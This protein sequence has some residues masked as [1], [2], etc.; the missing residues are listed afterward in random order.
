MM[1]EHVLPGYEI[2]IRFQLLGTMGSLSAVLDKAATFLSQ[3]TWWQSMCLDC[4]NRF[5]KLSKKSRCQ[6]TRCLHDK[7]TKPPSLFKQPCREPA[8]KS[9][10]LGVGIRLLGFGRSNNTKFIGA[11]SPLGPF[12]QAC[13]QRASDIYVHSTSIHRLRYGHY[14][15]PGLRTHSIK[16]GYGGKR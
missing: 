15:L 14:Y 5:F 13:S 9:R 7:S 1:A 8:F 4:S 12:S 6:N 3:D 10:T 2:T 16:I 11:A